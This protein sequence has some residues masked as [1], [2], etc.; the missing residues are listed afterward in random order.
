MGQVH[1]Q[2]SIRR[3][4]GQRGRQRLVVLDYLLGSSS[5]LDQLTEQVDADPVASLEQAG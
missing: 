3:R 5:V 1:R 2:P 4:R